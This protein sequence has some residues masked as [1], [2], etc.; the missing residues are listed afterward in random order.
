[1]AVAANTAWSIA[2][3]RREL[4]FRLQRAGYDTVAIA[5]PDEY[6][7]GIPCGF[8]PIQINRRGTNPFE[9]LGL[10]HALRDLYGRLRPAAVLHF[11]AKLNIYGTLAARRLRI[12]V[13]DNISGLGSGFL[14]GGPVSLIQKALYR[15]ALRHAELVFFQNPDDAAYFH[16]KRLIRGGRTGLLPGSGIDL[17]FFAP[18][19]KPAG[20]PFAFL[21]IARLIRDKGVYEYVE[22]ARRIRAGHPE[23]QFVLMGYLDHSN[24]T[25]ITAGE[26]KRWSAEGSVVLH[27]RNDDVREAIARSDCVVLPSYREGTPRSLL[28][29]ASMARPVIAT[30]VPGCRQVVEPGKTGYLCQVRDSADLA[31]KMERMLALSAEERQLMGRRGREKMEEEF[32]Q[33]IVIGRYLEALAELTG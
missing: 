11:T 9:D 10:L 14:G 31:D 21:L 30:D 26:L 18:R 20:Q 29:A 33:E 6:V 15:A 2:N 32:D 1:V 16:R 8:E 17:A 28:E 27:G 23:V 5:P 22:A 3:F 19:P 12:P 4:I 7:D 25:V 24:P 13:I